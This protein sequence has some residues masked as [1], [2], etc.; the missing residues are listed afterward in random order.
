MWQLVY[1]DGLPVPAQ[2]SSVPRDRWFHLHLASFTVEPLLYDFYFMG[3]LERNLGNRV[4]R[5][6]TCTRTRRRIRPL[7]LA[8]GD[9]GC[10]ECA[11]CAAQ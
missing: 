10:M 3:H 1:V 6:L 11:Q 4:V 2:W 8:G 9:S 7:P 5:A